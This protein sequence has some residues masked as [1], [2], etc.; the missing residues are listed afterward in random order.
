[1][2]NVVETLK[3]R[4]PTL[5]QN[6][7]RAKQLVRIQS[8]IREVCIDP[9]HPKYRLGKSLGEV[10]TDWRRV[11]IGERYR[12]FFRFFSDKN[13]IYFVWINDESTL[14][15]KGNRDDVYKVFA[16]KLDH[17]DFPADRDALVKQS[18]AN[19][20]PPPLSTPPKA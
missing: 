2:V 19:E 13:E 5:Y 17:E 15:K 9:D 1:M 20:T 12:L 4:D 18:E 10:H 14:R 11:K 3:E 8:A 16:A 7:F 6:M